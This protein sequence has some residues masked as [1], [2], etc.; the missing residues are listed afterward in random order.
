MIDNRDGCTTVSAPGKV[1]V[2][3]GYL[4]LDRPNVGVV[5]AAT[6]RFFSSVKWTDEKVPAPAHETGE[7][8]QPL[9]RIKVESPQFRSVHWYECV[10]YDGRLPILLAS[11]DQKPNVF[12][13][14][15][16]TYTLGYLLQAEKAGSGESTT[17]KD[18]LRDAGDR[19]HVLAIK[20]RADNDFYSQTR[21]LHARGLPCTSSALATLPPFLECPVSEDGAVVVAKTGMGSSAALVSSLVGAV[22]SFFGAAHL[23]CFDDNPDQKP[24]PEE[25]VPGVKEGL[26]LTHNLAQACHCVAQGKVGSGFDVSAAVY[27]THTYTRFSP[28]ELADALAAGDAPPPTSGTTDGLPSDSLTNRTPIERIATC[29]DARGGWD[30]ERGQLRL[31]SCFR[32]L[33]GDVCGGSSTPSMVR[34]VQAWR[35]HLSTAAQAEEVWS[36]LGSTNTIIANVLNALATTATDSLRGKSFETGAKALSALP[37]SRWAEPAGREAFGDKDTLELLFKLQAAFAKAR[38]LLREMGENAGVPI[39]PPVQTKLVDATLALPGVMCA[40]V[41]GA[42]GVDAVFAIVVHPDAE[43]GVRDLWASWRIESADTKG[44]SEGA[45]VCP[46]LL[47]A[48][49]GGRKGGIV[50]TKQMAW[51]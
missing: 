32:L 44:E 3:G 38:Q 35:A 46:L 39:E 30:A 51:D 23:P 34:K 16:L 13:E 1:L 42:G 6:A 48:S 17:V 19:G 20:L 12:V 25:N 24:S 33:M 2:A 40:G 10:V 8:S 4:V 7:R 28:N 29:V 45:V 49:E 41:P 11:S 22:L 26:D 21:Q 14:R 5:L 31:P 47:T 18:Y 27:G 15:A 43:D 37:S 9:V 36:E 50:C